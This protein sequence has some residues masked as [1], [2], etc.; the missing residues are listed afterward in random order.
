M[1]YSFNG[2]IAR[3]YGVDEAVF[4]HNLYWWIVKNE[5]NGRHYH[6]GRS[7]TYNSM[8]AFAKLFPFWSEKQV[9]R[10]VDRLRSAG[11][12]LVGNF[13]QSAMDRTQWYSLS[14]EVISVYRGTEEDGAGQEQD[15]R[16]Q[17]GQGEDE[18]AEPCAEVSEKGSLHLPKRSNG[19]AHMGGPIPDSKP[20]NKQKTYSACFE[21]LWAAYPNRRGKGRVTDHKK[22]ELFAVGEEQLMRCIERYLL[23]LKRDEWRK[24]QNGSTFF[25]SGY[26]DYLDENYT[27]PADGGDVWERRRL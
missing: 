13:N 22:R 10:I 12:L 27:P 16:E 17:S 9:R 1:D 24:P 8:A 21:R 2:E 15:E 11:A 5:A 3:R 18:Q 7:W 23:D 25:N 26:V 14:D 19:F 4:I 20:D 6:D